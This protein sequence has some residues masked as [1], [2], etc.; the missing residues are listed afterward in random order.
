MRIDEFIQRVRSEAPRVVLRRRRQLPPEM[1]SKIRR[2]GGVRLSEI[3]SAKPSSDEPR[4]FVYRHVLGPPASEDAIAK[5]QSKHAPQVLPAD[6]VGLVRNFNGIHLWADV[7]TGRATD[8]LAP[9]EEWKIA[10]FK[11]YGEKAKP[12]AGLGDRFVALSYDVDGGAY[13]V[14][15]TTSGEYFF[16]EASGPV[17]SLPIAANVEEL[18]DWLWRRRVDP[19]E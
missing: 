6:L 7:Q 11:M 16:V 4:E 5:W 18:L 14:L 2:P 12:D 8:G 3:L 19:G 15:D 1:L 17:P 9:I 10:R 13:V